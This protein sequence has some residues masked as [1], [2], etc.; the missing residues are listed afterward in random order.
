MRISKDSWH[1]RVWKFTYFLTRVD[2]LDAPEQTNLCRYMIRTILYPVP[3]FLWLFVMGVFGLSIFFVIP[4]IVAVLV[5]YGML[6]IGEPG[7]TYRLRPFPGI[8]IRGRT[9]PMWQVVSSSWLLIALAALMVFFPSKLK[10]LAFKVAI[11]ILWVMIGVSALLIL[12][13]AGL[14][15]VSVCSRWE[16]LDIMKEY[17]KA[18]RQRICPVIE[19]VSTNSHD[20]G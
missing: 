2:G 6:G 11:G 4:N 18:K 20:G 5:G 9:I 16:G 14:V 1:Y 15:I 7:E 13:Y 12:F 8:S 10:I 3:I 19:F 17:I